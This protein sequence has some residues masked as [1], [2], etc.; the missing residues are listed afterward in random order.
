MIK[1]RGNIYIYTPK[2]MPKILH[3]RSKPPPEG[4][5]T[6]EPTLKELERKMRDGKSTQLHAI[7]E[8]LFRGAAENKSH[9]GLRKA[10]SLWPIFRIHHQRSRYIYELYYKKH[11]ISKELYDYCLKNKYA[12][13]NLIAKWRKQ[14]YENL[15]CLRCIQAKDTNYGTTCICRVPREKLEKNKVVE[16]LSCGCRG[17]SG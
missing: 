10:E 17:C 13:I 16:C 3:S 6:I 4:W 12:D 1:T 11:L 14:G 7:L 8:S 9:E 2:K 5:E 15:C